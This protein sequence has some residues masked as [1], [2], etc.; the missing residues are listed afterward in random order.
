MII[1]RKQGVGKC[2]LLSVYAVHTSIFHAKERKHNEKLISCL[3]KGGRE[4]HFLKLLVFLP[5]LF[6]LSA[7]QI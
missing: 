7:L 5:G 3:V 2:K 4:K 1:N 6:L